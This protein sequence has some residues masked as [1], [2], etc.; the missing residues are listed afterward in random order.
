MDKH[1]HHIIKQSAERCEHLSKPTYYLWAANYQS[2]DDYVRDKNMYI[3]FG[4]RVVTYND[5]TAKDNIH[6]GLKT[7]IKYHF[8]ETD[9]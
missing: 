4:F 9:Y 5:T 8:Q 1:S 7:L 3:Q 2:Y 6:D